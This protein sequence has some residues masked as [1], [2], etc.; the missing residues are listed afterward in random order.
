MIDDQMWNRQRRWEVKR[1]ILIEFART[2]SDFEQA[3][4][5]LSTKVE[6]HGKSVYE[7][8][9]FRKALAG[10]NESSNKFERDSFGYGACR[11]DQ[12][13]FGSR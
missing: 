7:A 1:D 2:I 8:E 13:Y 6:N 11:I 4:V 9:L 5:N 10:W 3:V 12:A